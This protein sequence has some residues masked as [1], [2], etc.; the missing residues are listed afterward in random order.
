VAISILEEL[1]RIFVQLV[2]L[3]SIDLVNLNTV[4]A[5]AAMYATVLATVNEPPK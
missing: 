4:L 2:D 3:S 1:K 5:H